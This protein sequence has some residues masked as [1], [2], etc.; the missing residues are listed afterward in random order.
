MEGRSAEENKQVGGGGER[1]CWGMRLSP[2]R[3]VHVGIPRD[4]PHHHGTVWDLPG[5]HSLSST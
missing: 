3:S 2:L 4:E 1:K 5:K